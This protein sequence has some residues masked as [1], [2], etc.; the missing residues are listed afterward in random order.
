MA[1]F[2]PLLLSLILLFGYAVAAFLAAYSLLPGQLGLRW[3]RIS[4]VPAGAAALLVAALLV[5]FRQQTADLFYRLLRGGLAAGPWR[6]SPW[7]GRGVV[8]LVLLTALVA[9]YLAAHDVPHAVARA[10]RWHRHGARPARAQTVRAVLVVALAVAIVGSAF[11]T[12]RFVALGRQRSVGA[13][14]VSTYLLP[15]APTGMVLSDGEG[16]ITLGE[17]RVAR[18]ELTADGSQFAVDVVAEGL[19][20]PRGPA[21]VEGELLVVDLGQ[22]ACSDPFPQCWTGDPAEELDRINRSSARVLGFRISDD[23]QL[24]DEREVLGDL[25]VVNTEHAPSTLTPG[26]DGYVYLPIGAPD[27]MP[28]APELLD[29]ISHVNSS[30][31]GTVVRFRPGDDRVEVVATGLRNV[32]EVTF[33]PDGRMLGVDNGGEAAR[34]WRLEQLMEIMPGRDYGYPLFGTFNQSA[35]PPL[36]IL[37]ARASAGIA[38]ADAGGTPGVLVGAFEELFFVPLLS[39]ADGLY[40]PNR[41]I[42][43]ELMSDLGGFVTAIEPLGDDR[44]AVTVFDPSGARNALHVIELTGN[45]G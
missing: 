1:Q 29:D 2:Y 41:Q 44:F 15:G 28:R 9:V 45:G 20:F 23:G 36:W 19:S 39:D 25:P 14:I 12:E 31:L 21:I 35:P 38:W 33:D 27:R 3:G 22:L 5:G 6:L 42:V 8:A 7:A 26:P 18:F 4:L 13:R 24:A 40:V 32:F 43:R 34:G 30:L 17:G 37:D 10:K 16:Y 11:V